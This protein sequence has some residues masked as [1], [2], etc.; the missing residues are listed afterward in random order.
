MKIISYSNLNFGK[1][2][3][4]FIGGIGAGGFEVRADG[5]FYNC[6]IFN[7]YREEKMLDAFFI[8]KD[9]KGM[10]KILSTDDFITQTKVVE[11]VKKIEYIGEFP[12]VS[13]KFPSEKVELNFLSF[14]IPGDIKNSSL[15]SILLNLKGKGSLLFLISI[16]YEQKPLLVNNRVYLKSKDGAIG[17]YSKQ[18]K[19][20][21]FPKSTNIIRIF[22]K[23]ENLPKFDYR[24]FNKFYACL[25]WE[26]DF[27]DE[28]ILSWY[29]PDLRDLDG[30]RIG[31]YYENY[32]KSCEDV[33]DYVIKNKEFLKERTEEFYRSIY[34]VRVSKYLK[35][36]YTAQISTFV[37]E[38]WWTK[39]GKFGV[40]EGSKCCCGLQTT[41]VAYYGSWLYFN[42]F[43]EL[44][45]SGINLTAK[46]QRKD[47]FIPHFFPG[48]FKRIDEYR[49][50]DM[51][52]QFVLMVYRDFKFWN[53]IEFLKKM[54]RYVQKAIELVYK[55][56]NDGD[57]I[58]KIEG[59]DQTFDVWHW[60][61]CS[62]YIA[63]LWLATLRV[64]IEIGKIL[65]KENLR[66]K[67]EKDF[68]IVQ[69]NIIKKLWNGEYFIL[70]NNNGKKD[71][72]ALLDAL[73]G[74]WYC[75]ILGLGHILPEDMIK[76]HLRYCLKHNRKK[77]DLSY[78]KDYSTPGEIGYC[79]INGAYKDER[80]VCFQQYESWTGIEYAFAI[81]LFIM[82]MKKDSLKV[83]KDVYKRKF[84]SGMFYNHIECGGDYFRPMV[85]GLLWE[86]FN[87]KYKLT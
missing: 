70:W 55:W 25:M 30:N 73:S 5:K 22:E 53:D 78:M 14:F 28:L 40:W 51:N 11:G 76:S 42:L 59:P 85:I 60:E 46:F 16:P 13:L 33:L 29:F 1:R 32:F 35:D 38:S 41:D 68:K 74:D 52:M 61:G 82:G 2:S 23:N 64:G 80:K 17:I 3:G 9:N 48:T 79:Y 19:I 75:Y 56:D 65:N 63:V 6:S 45:K 87:K 54:F 4:V 72:A 18:A 57:L 15:P 12:K 7:E 62:I 43:K 37:K 67:C 34:N 27:N 77:M 71:E 10:I 21:L 8:H 50:K 69:E 58:P 24:K 66:L 86:L 36:S 26:G 39:D 81:H 47:G 83:I 49:R 20:F 44:E 84:R 31:H